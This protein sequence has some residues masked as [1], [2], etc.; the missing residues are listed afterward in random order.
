MTLNAGRR[1]PNGRI[2]R[3]ESGEPAPLSFAQEQLVL[4]ESE[5]PGIP[6]LYNECITLRIKGSLDTAALEHSFAEIIR[7]HEIWRTSYDRQSGDL[8]QVVHPPDSEFRLGI[9]DLRGIPAARQ[10][11]EAQQVIGELVREPFDLG[12]GPLLR[13]RLIRWNDGEHQLS[14]AAHLS[15]VDGVSVYQIFP[16]ELMAL[17]QAYRCGRPSPLAPLSLQFG[18]YAAWQRKS[19][20]E[21]GAAAELAYWRT[22]LAG[23]IPTLRWPPGRSR[24]RP[25]FRGKIRPFVLPSC[26]RDAIRALGQEEG[27]T[28]FAVL[29]AT[30]AAL[31]HGYTRQED[32]IIGTPSAAGRKQPELQGLLGHFLNPVALRF[33]LSGSLTFRDLLRQTQGLILDALSNDRMPIDLLEQELKGDPSHS[34]FFTVAA[35]LQPPMPRLELDWSITSMDVDSGGAPWELYLAFID[36]TEGLMGRVQYNPD[37]FDDRSIAGM[38]ENYDRLSV[39]VRADPEIHLSQLAAVVQKTTC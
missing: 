22:Q 39:V 38:L 4:R 16:R 6:P 3:R 24:L 10:Q 5:N 28:Q 8:I 14:L 27:T 2:T 26:R 29:M 12:K 11:E 35:S 37:L 18:D 31:L 17:Y 30:L 23:E 33:D 7:R 20:H 15:I 21:E 13:A 36:R 19:L 34:G 9:I 25:T 1:S 32:I